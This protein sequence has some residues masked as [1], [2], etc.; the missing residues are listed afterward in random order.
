MVVPAS[1]KTIYR[2]DSFRAD[3]THSLRIRE[4]QLG[5]RS[6]FSPFVNASFTKYPVTIRFGGEA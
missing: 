1:Q 6:D 3:W 2:V 5:L 4:P